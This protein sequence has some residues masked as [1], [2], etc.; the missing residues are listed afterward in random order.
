MG[1]LEYSIKRLLEYKRIADKAIAQISDAAL[2]HQA[3]SENENSIVVIVKHMRGNMLSR[4]TNFLTED[5]E[6]TWRQREEEFEHENMTRVHL[7]ELWEEGWA[8]VFDTLG[9]LTE[10]DL[11]HTIHIR[12]EPMT[13]MDAIMRQLMHYS[14]HIGQIV[15]LCKEE[16]GDNWQSLSIPKGGSAAFNATMA[17]KAK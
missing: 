4:W 5:G 2:L 17:A 10:E 3:A 15:L 9:N 1:F 8:C 14:Y 16:A 6:K 13:A 11:Q 7:L 12:N